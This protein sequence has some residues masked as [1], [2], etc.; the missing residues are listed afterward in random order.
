MK[1]RKL[2]AA[3]AAA[4]VATLAVSFGAPAPSGSIVATQPS[5]CC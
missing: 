1:T 5:G 2:L 4:L 3:T